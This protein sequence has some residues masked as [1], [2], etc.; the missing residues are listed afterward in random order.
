MGGPASP[1]RPLYPRDP[2]SLNKPS[3]HPLPTSAYIGNMAFLKDA[4]GLEVHWGLAFG[5]VACV[6]AYVLIDHSTFGFAVRMTGGNVRAAQAAG[7]S[8][9][10]LILVTCS[11]GGAA[12]GLAGAVQIAAVEHQANSAVYVP[13]FGFTG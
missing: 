3:T 2:A 12:A 13:N 9:G 4:L 1:C 6:L 7:L 5:I 11:L 8:V 10:R